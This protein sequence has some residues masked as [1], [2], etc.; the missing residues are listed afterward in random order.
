[1]KIRYYFI[2]LTII[3]VL[4]ASCDN[5]INER[6][7]VEK[8][9][10]EEIKTIPGFEWLTQE[11]TLYEPNTESID[12]CKQAF[13]P[14]HHYFYIYAKPAC[15]CNTKHIIF[16]A[17]NKTMSEIGISED[18]FDLFIIND[19][20]DIHPYENVL[21]INNIPAFYIIKD[22]EVTFSV[23][24]SLNDEEG[25]VKDHFGQTT[26]AFEDVLLIGL[27]Q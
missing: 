3:P 10:L 4:F 24:D 17:I 7:E 12:G 25:F 14:A 19:I 27:E 16:A 11:T 8:V 9:T 15:S 21:T 6:G 13:D 20:D 26:P 1:M 18:N 23:L 22:N 5:D 2:L